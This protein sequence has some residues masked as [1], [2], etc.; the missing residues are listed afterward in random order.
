MGMLDWCDA[1]VGPEGIG[2]RHIPYGVKGSLEGLLQGDFV[3]DCGSGARGSHL[4]QLCLESRLGFKV[5][6]VGDVLLQG[7]YGLEHW[8]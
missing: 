6:G 7:W 5:R 3:L 4:S 1:R 8:V 2:P